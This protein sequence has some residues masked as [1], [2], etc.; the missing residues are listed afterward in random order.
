MNNFVEDR[1]KFHS[2]RVNLLFGPLCD[3]YWYGELGEAR[4]G[5]DPAVLRCEQLT[6]TR[7]K[8]KKASKWLQ[9]KSPEIWFP[10][11]TTEPKLAESET[12][13]LWAGKVQQCHWS[14][15]GCEKKKWKVALAT[16]PQY[17]DNG[18]EPT[19]Q[20][21]TIWFYMTGQRGKITSN[22]SHCSSAKLFISESL[23]T[24]LV[25]LLNLLC[26]GFFNHSSAY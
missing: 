24:H 12:Q 15:G 7:W 9:P 20:K 1:L 18:S 19:H 10:Q 22:F 6:L 23:I 26:A 16:I 17:D 13:T 5:Q 25:C 14:V 3:G 8:P 21:G 4:T 11:C 2:F